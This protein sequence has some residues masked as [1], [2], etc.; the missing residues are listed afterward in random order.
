ML[1]VQQQAARLT[2]QA[3]EG[4]LRT[5]EFVPAEKRDWV[6]EGKARTYHDFM[7]ECAIM[8]DWGARF[9]KTGEFPPFDREAYEKAKAGL[10]TLE[11]IKTAG[12]AGIERICAAIEAVPDAKLGETILTPWG[13]TMTIAD[14][15]FTCYW[16]LVYHWGQVNYIQMLLGDT[17]MH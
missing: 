7:A 8:A 6:P 16:N 4:L 15:L 5:A 10:D 2:R 3:W 11:K 9:L 12:N 14:M 1:T 17:E 13:M